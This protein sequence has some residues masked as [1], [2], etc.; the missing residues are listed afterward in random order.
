MGCAEHSRLPSGTGCATLEVKLN[1]VCPV[2]ENTGQIRCLAEVLSLGRR[3]ATAQ[4]S[5][6]D[7]DGKLRGHAT[8]TC[9]IFPI[10]ADD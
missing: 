4:A 10:T 2:V 3:S 5:I 7:L 8:T 1:F 6:I 9:M